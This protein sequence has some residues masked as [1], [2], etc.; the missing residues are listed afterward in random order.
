MGMTVREGN[1]EYFYKML[2]RYFPE[3]RVKYEKKYGNNYVVSS[4]NSRELM[5]F[6]LETCKGNNI[7]CDNEKIFKYMSTLEEKNRI[8][9]A[10][11]DLF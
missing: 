11:L 7:V 10:E 5:A 3:L 4:D 9:Q 6:F 1:R 8:V 2:D